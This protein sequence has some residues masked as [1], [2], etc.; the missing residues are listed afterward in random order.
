MKIAKKDIMRTV[1]SFMVMSIV[2]VTMFMAGAA[3]ESE[4]KDTR[5]NTYVHQGKPVIERAEYHHIVIRGEA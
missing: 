5:Y 3:Y 1:T 2:L 4:Q